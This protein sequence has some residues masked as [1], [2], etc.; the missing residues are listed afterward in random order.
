V[1][2]AL[3]SGG[4]QRVDVLSFARVVTGRT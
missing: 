3:Q 2:R 4:V 1:T